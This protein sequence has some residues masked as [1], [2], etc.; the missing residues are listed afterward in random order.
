MKFIKCI[1]GALLAA[2]P[3]LFIGQ[4]FGATF[5]SVA[6]KDGHIIVLISGEIAEGDSDALKAAIKT[7]NDAG[8]FVSGVRLNS[9]GGNL[10]EGVKLAA[11]VKF[12]KAATNVAKGG[13]CASAC[14][15]VFAAGEKKFANYAARVGVHGA[16]DQNGEETTRSGAATV[17]MAKVAKELGV[18]DA[19]IGRMV[20]TPPNEMVWLTPTDLQSMGT[21]MVGKPSQ[22]ATDPQG[23]T[24]SAPRQTEPSNP[25]DIRPTSKAAAPPSWDDMVKAAALASSKQNGGKPMTFRVCQPEFKTCNNGVVFQSKGKDVMVKVTRNLDEIIIRREVCSFNESG[26]IRRCLDWDKNTIHR[27]MKDSSG[28]WVKVADE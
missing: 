24:P 17:S 3:L 7:A 28:T 11:A 1:R 23:A 14:F 12:A 21:T 6:T 18:P 16:S 22:V 26:D 8:K 20:V 19:I 27:D 15:L 2:A 9:P 25:M 13:T 4:A 5:K 10:L